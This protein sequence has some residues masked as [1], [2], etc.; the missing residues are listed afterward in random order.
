MKTILY[1]IIAF[2]FIPFI[3]ISQDKK[4]EPKYGISWSGFV[5]NDFFYDT[6]QTV[7]AREGH[8]L[9][10][11]AAEKL[12]PNGVDLNDEASFNFLSIQSRLTGKITGPDAFGAKTSGVIEGAFFGH[13]DPDVN[14]FRLRHAFVKLNWE[15]AELITGQYW[16]PLFETSCFPDVVSFNTGSG[17]QPFARNPQ[18]RFTYKLSDL[19]V[20]AVAFSE[21]D[22][23]SRGPSGTNSTY[24]RNAGM[25][26]THL[27]IRYTKK[28]ED[29]TGFVFGLGGGMLS[30]QP[31][32]VTGLGYKTDQLV[33][34][35]NSNAY[36]RLNTKPVT[37]KLEAVYGGNMPNLLMFGGYAI[38][39]TLNFT[40]GEVEWTPI[41]NLAF[42]TDIHT[43][44]KKIQAGIFAGYNMNMGTNETVIGGFQGL[45]TS[46]S[47][48][49]RVSP[50]VMFNSG[51][52]RFSTEIE[53]TAATYGD[54]TYDGNAIPQNTY[55]VS[56]LRLLF[57][58]Y[59][60]F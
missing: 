7:N 32:T 15:K 6:R 14:G 58:T 42:W 34:S 24:I 8:F 11:P 56:N 10:W 23:T 41:N 48:L 54:G 35:I 4:E 46:I 51:K 12:D 9:L 39:D 47:S 22:F 49:L 53:Y 28:N 38:K 43:N 44:G 40:T 31:Q 37:L 13:S 45:S 18:I 33:T 55:T 57:A 25:P 2:L 36:F 1:S 52:F 19:E 26:A 20:Y 16:H 60:F 59:Y 27:G 5:K 50:R 21:R 17:I 29:G 30:I 3:V